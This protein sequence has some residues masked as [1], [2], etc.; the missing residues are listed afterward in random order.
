MSD[1]FGVSWQLCHGFLGN[2]ADNFASVS[3]KKKK[4]NVR[5]I[6][7]YF[8]AFPKSGLWVFL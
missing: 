7:F 8:L 1:Y 3:A 4:K 2:L 5:E 6:A